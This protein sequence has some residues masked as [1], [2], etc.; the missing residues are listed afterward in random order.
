MSGHGLA[1]QVWIV[2]VSQV[3]TGYALNRKVLA[4]QVLARQDTAGEV[5]LGGVCKV[6]ASLSL[7]WQA[8]H[9]CFCCGVCAVSLGMFRFGLAGEVGLGIARCV[10]VL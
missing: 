4:R 3:L 7:V 6:V 2:L 1:G 10:K 8:R 5:S 9:G